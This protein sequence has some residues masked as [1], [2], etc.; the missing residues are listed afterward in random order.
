[1][2]DKKISALA[3]A[4]TPLTGT[5]ILPVV[6]SGATVNVS[7]ANITAGRSI[8]ASGLTLSG[9]TANTIPYLNASNVVTTST[10]LQF[11]GTNIGLGLTPNASV[12]RSIESSFG[13]VIGRD[14]ANI[15]HNAYYGASGWTY[16]SSNFASQA[17]QD[18]GA[19][20][21]YTAPSGTAGN[22]I[23]FS[24]RMSLN[25]P[26]NLTLNS[27]NLIVGTA[28]KGIDFSANGGDVLSQYDE[29]TWTVVWTN[30]TGTPAS[31]TGYYTRI[32]RVVYFTY[33][34]GSGSIT[35]VAAST[36]FSL[37]FTPLIEAAGTQI[38]QNVAFSA[39]TL[40][41]PSNSSCYVGTFTSN[42]M[43]FSGTYIV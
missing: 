26:G 39:T 5:E 25:Q 17:Y 16:I 35:A 6:Q 33:S 9:G 43:V 18:D 1:M 8:S 14:A 22:L 42:F 41:L 10:A 23:S 3:A 12:L 27:G 31:T 21:W 20:I 37:P 36:R 32:G 15:V 4:S 13:I 2:V 34:P 40:I 29:G 11:D 38:S 7:I 28:G 19:H 30:L 24:E